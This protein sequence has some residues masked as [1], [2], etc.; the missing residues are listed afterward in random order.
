M[1]ISIIPLI[2]MSGCLSISSEICFESLSVK[3][4]FLPQLCVLSSHEVYMDLF[5]FSVL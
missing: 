3:M 4:D 2:V 5:F 1:L